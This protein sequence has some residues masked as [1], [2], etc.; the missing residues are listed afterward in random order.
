MNIE[1]SFKKMCG[2]LFTIGV[3]TLFTLFFEI[4]TVLAAT[5]TVVVSATVLPNPSDFETVLE[6]TNTATSVE[7]NTVIDYR[8]KYSSFLTYPTTLVVTAKWNDGIVVDEG[9]RQVEIIDYFA[10]SASNGYN[11]TPPVI[12]LVNRKI[13]WTITNF[14]ANT[15]DQII[16]YSLKT[17]SNYRGSSQVTFTTN[18]YLSVGMLDLPQET[19]SKT[20]IYNSA[21]DE[22][23]DD[24]DESSGTDEEVTE[25]VTEVV[26]VLMTDFRFNKIQIREVGSTFVTLYFRSNKNVQLKID[27]GEK[28]DFLSQS[29]ES[30][31]YDRTQ[32]ITINGL[33]PNKT[34]YFRVTAYD[35]QGNYFS[36]G[37]YEIKTA[38]KS[39][40]PEVLSESVIITSNGSILSDSSLRKSDKN[41]ENFVVIPKNQ[42][43]ELKFGL[44]KS[45]VV[46]RVQVI[47]RKNGLVSAIGN[48][49]NVNRVLGLKT[50]NL[51]RIPDSNTIEP[52]EVLDDYFVGVIGSP[53]LLG[54][55]DIVSR[56]SDKYGSILERKIAGLKVIDNFKLISSVNNTPIEGAQVDFY[57]LDLR[58][59]N[60]QRLEPQKFAVSNPLYTDYKGEIEVV[61]PQG[62][63]KGKVIALGFEEKEVKFEI[64]RFSG[65]EL[66]VIQL[67]KM[68][69][70]IFTAIKYYWT[71][72]SDVSIETRVHV[73]N[74]SKSVR[75]FEL[76]A[77]LVVVVLSFLTLFSLSSRLH[78]P[79]HSL[80][81]YIVHHGKILITQKKLGERIK[82]RV[83]DESSNSV[84]SDADVFL[85]DSDKRKVVS[86]S[87]TNSQGDFSFIK[88]NTNRYELEVM[89]ESYEPLVFKESDIQ[90]IGLGGYLL[91]IKKRSAGLNVHEKFG[92]YFNK[93][94]SLLFE[95]LLITLIVFE[96]SLGYALGWSKVFPFLVFAIFNLA[97][98]IIHLSHQRSEK[99]IF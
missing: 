60:Y 57:Y 69:F 91:S 24:S 14:P 54:N 42:S 95:T 5:G 63:Y 6:T 99:N 49:I 77:L 88:I 8:I 15:V 78:I 33:E 11:N 79:L 85:I 47:I 66:P 34:Y 25:S 43:I 84:L 4:T 20:Y 39:E 76:N 58:T 74:L 31:L 27:Y 18:A 38:I 70:N 98:W 97:L 10:G 9:S 62:S 75:F 64:G 53:K 21:L 73:Q 68:S 72:L 92:I 56:I 59:K 45:E 32:E 2:K 13:T 36:S 93:F 67:Q 28:P 61:L 50:S 37:I 89:K 29:V 22:D 48:D 1:C 16:T 83:F 90:E 46:K 41:G 7:Q 94:A 17:N 23:K 35:T 26:P 51:E 40:A 3:F 86:H 44:S 80:Y 30:L 71:I 81:E 12:D 19:V 52:V 96:V 87:K 55:Y 82:G 65:Q